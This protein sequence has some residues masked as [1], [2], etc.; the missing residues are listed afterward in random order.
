MKA[1]PIPP[2]GIV[3]S[4][5]PVLMA[6]TL[7]PIVFK[8]SRALGDFFGLFTS[9]VGKHLDLT[10]PGLPRLPPP[11]PGAKWKPTVVVET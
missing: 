11:A 3:H 6:N 9:G 7:L 10:E 2:A 4:G 1:F 5:E 8:C